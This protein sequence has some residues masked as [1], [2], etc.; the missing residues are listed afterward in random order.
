[1]IRLTLSKYLLLVLFSKVKYMMLIFCIELISNSKI[2]TQKACSFE[3]IS[4]SRTLMVEDQKY[5]WILNK[6]SWTLAKWYFIHS[7]M[8]S[9][10]EL[11]SQKSRKQKQNKFNNFFKR[12]KSILSNLPVHIISYRISLSKQTGESIIGKL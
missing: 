6:T 1:L 8:P 12:I 10:Q 4:P 5:C 3:I 9:Y 7:F 11:H 2:H